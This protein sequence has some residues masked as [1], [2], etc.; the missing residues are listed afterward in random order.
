VDAA[1]VRVLL[2]AFLEA[3]R[4]GDLGKLE[5]V[6]ADDVVSVS[7]GAGMVARAAR[8]PVVGR[9]QVAR[10]VAA[11]AS[12]FWTSTTLTWLT[13]NGAP[14]VLITRDGDPIALLG[15]DAEGDTITCLR[16]VMVPDKLVLLDH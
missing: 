16:W 12:H 1:Q 6:L 9:D 4:S 14:S 5:Q 15:I 11:F 8:R 3:A 13:T 2:E 10:F 7:D